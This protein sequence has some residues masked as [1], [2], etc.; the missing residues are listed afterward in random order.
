MKLFL[1]G[2]LM[3]LEGA[4]QKAGN[5]ELAPVHHHLLCAGALWHLWGLAAS[6]LS[7]KQCIYIYI[8]SWVSA[9]SSDSGG[10]QRLWGFCSSKCHHGWHP[11]CSF[12]AEFLLLKL[13][14]SELRSWELKPAVTS[15][16]LLLWSRLTS[17][18]P[19][20]HHQHCQ[21]EKDPTNS[22]CLGGSKFE[23][24]KGKKKWLWDSWWGQNSG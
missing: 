10:L 8:N 22:A 9:A 24:L 16:C 6:L 1:N 3:W 19:T 20:C 18:F 11:I 23:G 5:S 12:W 15:V 13:E 14:S 2:I 21:S 7:T 17:L 4:L